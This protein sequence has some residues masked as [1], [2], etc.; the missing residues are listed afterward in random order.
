MLLA[1]LIAWELSAP[2]RTALP[3]RLDD[4]DPAHTIK[5]EETYHASVRGTCWA[6]RRWKW[7]NDG[8]TGDGKRTALRAGS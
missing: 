6:S 7:H 3:I 5:T 4:A 8:P 2:P 1:G